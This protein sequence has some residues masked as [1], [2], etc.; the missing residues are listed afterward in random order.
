VK[1][2]AKLLTNEKLSKIIDK[3]GEYPTRYRTSIWEYLLQLP[4][5]VVAYQNLVNK[6][7]HPCATTLFQTFPI[8]NRRYVFL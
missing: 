3:Y 8:K 7:T 1:E 2:D 5:N 4:S 6:G